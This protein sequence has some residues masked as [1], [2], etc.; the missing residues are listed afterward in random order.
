[1]TRALVL[2]LCLAASARSEDPVVGIPNFR[3]VVPGVYRGGRPRH[4]RARLPPLPAWPAAR[5]ESLQRQVDPRSLTG[6]KEGIR[7]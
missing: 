7:P 5:V 2:V 4:D 1:M 6:Q 3:E